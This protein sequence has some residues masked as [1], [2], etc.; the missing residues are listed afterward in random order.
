MVIAVLQN[1]DALGIDRPRI[2]MQDEREDI[3]RSDRNSRKI[4]NFGHT[5]AHALEKVT[6]YKRFKHGEAVGL[7]VLFAGELS[8]RLDILDANELNLL[9]GV[10]RRVGQLPD[11]GNISLE[12]VFESFA[13]DKKVVGKSLQWILLE[14]IGQPVIV[15]NTDIATSIVKETLEKVLRDKSAPKNLQREDFVNEK[16]RNKKQQKNTSTVV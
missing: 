2:V 15:E 14:K 11:T 6:N 13:F 8:K 5:L 7:G 16:Y 3:L 9:N 12:K 1:F 10:L 4:L